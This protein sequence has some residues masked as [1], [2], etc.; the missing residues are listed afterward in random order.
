MLENISRDIGGKKKN[1]WKTSFVGNKVCLALLSW[2]KL[3]TVIV[4]SEE[5]LLAALCF[6]DCLL[7]F[8]W[9]SPHISSSPSDCYLVSSLFSHIKKKSML[10]PD[11]AEVL[12]P[13]LYKREG[14][15]SQPA[16]EWDRFTKAAHPFP[17]SLGTFYSNKPF[18]YFTKPI[19]WL[20]RFY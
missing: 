3:F 18:Q 12:F 19:P 2:N 17:A 5:L 15:K 1:N 13:F 4:S 9:Y 7:S 16:T 14:E 20:M 8:I 10:K 6:F 11:M